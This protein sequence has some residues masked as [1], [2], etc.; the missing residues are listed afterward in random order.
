MLVDENEKAKEGKLTHINSKDV[1]EEAEISMHE[2][3]LTENVL[4]SQFF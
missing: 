2:I 1:D 4:F 3:S